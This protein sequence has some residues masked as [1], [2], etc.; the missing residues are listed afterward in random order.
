MRSE[1]KIYAR[2]RT[3]AAWRMNSHN[4]GQRV[5]SLQLRQ[6]HL[7]SVSLLSMR[8]SKS[9]PASLRMA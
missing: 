4:A 7:W 1:I 2:S 5:N 8:Y 6:R 9:T 3:F